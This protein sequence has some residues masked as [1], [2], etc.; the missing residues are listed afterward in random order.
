[1]KK[2]ILLL[3][4]F[5]SIG[6]SENIC[7]NFELPPQFS[8]KTFSKDIIKKYP[9]YIIQ[10]D[11]FGVDYIEKYGNIVLKHRL[12][13]YAKNVWDEFNAINYL[14]ACGNTDAMVAVSNFYEDKDIK[15]Y[16]L[17]RAAKLHNT[18]AISKVYSKS[19]YRNAKEDKKVAFELLQLYKNTKIKIIKLKIA[20]MLMKYK[21]YFDINKINSKDI[22]D[23]PYIA[24]EHIGYRPSE[25]DVKKLYSINITEAKDI[26]FNYFLY[27]DKKLAE[28][29]YQKKIELSMEEFKK[30]YPYYY[31]QYNY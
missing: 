13:K 2:I 3:I 27:R 30:L 24:I 17:I 14:A 20:S 5:I 31:N 12:Q 25:E 23:N 10:S 8:I 9:S 1:M 11:S 7:P 28:K 26:L 4:F 6:Y 15:N 29:Y 16:W 19:A 21:K 22:N 18:K